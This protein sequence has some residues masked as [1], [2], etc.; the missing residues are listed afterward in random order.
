MPY[1][2]KTKTDPGPDCSGIEGWWRCLDDG[3][4][5]AIIGASLLA[6]AIIVA[7]VIAARG[8]RRR[9]DRSDL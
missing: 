6:L 9:G 1:I 3:A 2:I 7:A 5:A 4:Q 8:R